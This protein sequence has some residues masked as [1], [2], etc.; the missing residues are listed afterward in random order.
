MFSIYRIDYVYQM[1]VQRIS[2]YENS[3]A[4]QVYPQIVCQQAYCTSNSQKRHIYD[5]HLLPAYD[6]RI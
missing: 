4:K 2:Q 1:Y 5:H 6:I 3:I